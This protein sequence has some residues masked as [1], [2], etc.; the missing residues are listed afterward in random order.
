MSISHKKNLEKIS[1]VRFSVSLP[2]LASSPTVILFPCYTDGTVC[3]INQ[4]YPEMKKTHYCLNHS[5]DGMDSFLCST[6]SLRNAHYGVIV[7][8]MNLCSETQR[9]PSRW[10]LFSAPFN[11]NRMKELW[12]D[13]TR[14]S[15]LASIASGCFHTLKL[16]Y[17]VRC[18]RTR[19]HFLHFQRK[20][21][22]SVVA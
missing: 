12:K 10:P 2:S 21:S 1:P 15:D 17:M 13:I 18:E 16:R 5:W 20:C 11:V 19:G 8:I 3:C 9:W 22:T 14:P 4:H 7:L 6:R